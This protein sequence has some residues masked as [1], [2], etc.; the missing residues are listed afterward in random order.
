MI[1]AC[2]F[3][4]ALLPAFLRAPFVFLGASWYT[5]LYYWLF[6]VYLGMRSFSIPWELARNAESRTTPRTAEFPSLQV[7]SRLRI[8]I[9]RPALGCVCVLEGRG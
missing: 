2:C 5:L 1:L 8:A 7:I 9:L 6:A 4:T 3:L